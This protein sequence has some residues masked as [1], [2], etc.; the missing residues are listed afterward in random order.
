MNG[1]MLFALRYA[2]IVL[3]LS[4]VHGGLCNVPIVNADEQQSLQ[5]VVE[6]LGQA[7]E[8]RLQ[9]SLMKGML[10]GLTGR[11][12]V[13]APAGWKAVADRLNQSEDVDVR[14]LASELAQVFGDKAAMDR[15]MLQV[16][17]RFTAPEI[18]RRALYSLLTQKHEPAAELLE[19][20]LTEKELQLDAIRG[21]ALIEHPRA[22]EILLKN[23]PDWPAPL[24]KATLE[25]LATRRNYAHA[26]LAA[27]EEKLIAKEE[28]PAHVARS[29]DLLLGE[30]FANV[31]GEVRE[32][33]QDRNQLI[34]RY[35]E[36]L[37][38]EALAEA[39][40]VAGRKVFQ[41][42]CA[43]CHK[44]YGDGG[45]IGPD[46]TGSNR[47]NLDYILL[48]SVDPSYDVPEGYRMVLIE[49]VDGLVLNGVVAEE[50]AQSVTLKTV[51]QPRVVVLK[52]DI[53]ERKISTKS[54]MPDGQFEALKQ[55]E[56]RNLILYLRSTQQV[57]ASE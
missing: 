32:L 51:Q 49:T 31:F 52:T 33:D 3:G 14:E 37:T 25:T 16:Q 1:T 21:Y 53:A 35:K 19:N 55:D 39:D 10:A 8:P 28:V 22:A 44:L 45:D 54:I 29:M 5:L 48:N 34:A 17:D 56:L 24:Q 40:P 42:T 7:K 47:A 4:L 20:L 27:I 13:P 43:S 18:R 38:D 36:L 41:K 30:S 6:S 2:S 26:L 12:D 50:N 23:Y 11:R 15:A 57:E 9:I 46:L